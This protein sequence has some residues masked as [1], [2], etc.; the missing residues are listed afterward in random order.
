MSDGETHTTRIPLHPKLISLRVLFQGPSAGNNDRC[1]LFRVDGLLEPWA[2][3]KSFVLG[4]YYLTRKDD[5]HN[6]VWLD[7]VVLYYIS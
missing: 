5:G 2:Q 6:G 4:L 7:K 3:L 1:S